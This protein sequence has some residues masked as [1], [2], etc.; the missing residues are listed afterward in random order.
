[1]SLAL[2]ILLICLLVTAPVA[3]RAQDG[4]VA[5][6]VDALNAGLDQ[7]PA[8]IDRATPRAT[9]ESLLYAARTQ[10]WEAAAH[11]LNLNGYPVE[12]QPEVGPELARKLERV[13][14][15]K[16]VID[17]EVL[18]DR[19]DGIDADAPDRL[20]LAGEPRKSILLWTLRLGDRPTAI[21]LN[22]VRPG[23]GE[24]VWVFSQQTV[25]SIEALHVRYGPSRLE[26]L[27][28]PELREQTAIGLVVW[29]LF[30]LP[31]LLLLAALAGFWMHRLL[32]RL[33]RGAERQITTDILR[34]VRG[35]AVFGTVAAILSVATSTL[36][37]FSGEIDAVIVPIVWTAVAISIVW[38][39]VNALDAV[40]DRL[41]RFEDDLTKREEEQRRSV[42]TKVSA[43]R[44][45]LIV[46]ATL[47]GAGFVLSRSNA[48][49]NLGVSLI[50]A[51]GVLTLILAFAARRA[52]SNIMSSLQ[53]A[54][55]QSAKIGD[56]IVYDGHLCHVERINFTF[57]Q[58][59][60][61]DGTR[62]VV[63]VEEFASR[64]FEN[65]T[66]QEP[67]ML[68][69][70]KLQLAHQAD[71]DR[72]REAF[73]EVVAELDRDELGDLGEVEVRVA[74][75]DVFAKEVWFCLPCADPNTSW[76]MACRA[77][78][79]I[80]ARATEIESGRGAQVFPEATPAEAA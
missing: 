2:R 64:V 16:A 3:G 8:T 44:R 14:A 69:I 25:D 40:L 41:V 30:A 31:L 50:G 15:R 46:L 34:A 57:V 77:R 73:D 75:Q 47:A 5:Y 11:L 23:G 49:D 62:L 26:R 32:R 56:R 79:K 67:E 76:G 28:P 70:I 55:N 24:P 71:V 65:W 38:L 53:I 6:R 7:A 59:R 80:I 21:R 22:R 20:A 72:L 37:V 10:R 17:W 43:G 52:L 54:L 13:I 45:A 60:D 18:I 33:W 61:W 12:R 35:P 36:F 58:L 63:P 74:G 39:L 19:P 4:D 29:E 42:A 66:M 68:R 27:L 51:A 48:L 78:E 1:M 9:L